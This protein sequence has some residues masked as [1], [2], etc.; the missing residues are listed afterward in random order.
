MEKILIVDDDENIRYSF[1]RMLKDKD[2]RILEV[3][4][5][6]EAIRIISE[7]SID[8][9]IMDVRLPGMSGI[10]ALR[11]IKEGRSKLLIIVITAYGTTDLAIEAMKR[12]AFDYLLKPFDI[13]EMKDLI[14]KGLRIN[15]LMRDRVTF[16]LDG[17]KKATGEMPIIGKSRKMQ[18][19]FKTIGQVA[20]SD[21]TVLIEGESGTGKELIARA[22]YHH[23]NLADGPFLAVNCAAIPET[24]LESELFGYEKGAFTG[25]T[26]LRIGKFEQCHR[27]TIFLDEIG[28]MSPLTQTKVLRVLQERKFERVGGNK[29]IEVD[30]RVI[31]A[32]NQ[33]LLKAI[34]EGRFR[35]DLYYRLNT[36]NIKLPS[37]RE[38]KEDISE[39]AQFFLG[40]YNQEFCRNVYSISKAALRRL[41]A[42]SWPGNVRELENVIKRSV[43]MAKG[44]TLLPDDIMLEEGD[45]PLVEETQ[46]SSPKE[47]LESLIKKF[48]YLGD[49][50]SRGPLLP[51]I[52][53]LLIIHALRETNGN[54]VRAAKLLGINRHTLKYRIKKY[55][56]KMD[57][58]I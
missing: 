36:V 18:E 51:T 32:T 45:V 6:E 11:Q 35:E 21:V 43:L 49:K 31:A 44:D 57:F 26:S 8:L 37:L 58:N 22:I 53:R 47:T 17:Q 20:Q 50:G 5:G 29:T 3:S 28:D 52:E 27:G 39:L 25:A 23:S 55:G 16:P 4:T 56:I 9:V 13:E 30:V 33:N 15:R 34:K 41:K 1:R 10:E 12:G 38:R 24:L 2:Y 48:T 7:E 42:Y 14:E 40:K 19:V 46:I 54:Q